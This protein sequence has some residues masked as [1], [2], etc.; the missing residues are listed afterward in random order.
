[1][2]RWFPAH[3][4]SFGIAISVLVLAV[5]GYA[6]YNL[7]N[8]QG[9]IKRVTKRVVV[10]EKEIGPRGHNG[11]KGP[12]GDSGPQGPAGLRGAPGLRG[13]PGPPGGGGVVG[14]RG[15]AGPRGAPGVQ[16]PRGAAGKQGAPGVQGPP[17]IGPVGPPGPPGPAGT[18]CPPGYTLVPVTAKGLK[19]LFG[20]GF[21]AAVVCAQ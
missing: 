2:R 7:N 3:R 20:S 15:Q 8:Q 4:V 16:G 17:G 14:S 9:E 18:V 12:R 5:W 13:M 10:I 19:M 1:M 11:P 21:T 6:V